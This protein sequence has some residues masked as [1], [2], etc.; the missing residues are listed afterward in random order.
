MSAFLRLC[1]NYTIITDTSF[2][3]Q[4]PEHNGYPLP[5]A[6]TGNSF[7]YVN[8]SGISLCSLDL[9]NTKNALFSSM[10]VLFAPHRLEIH[11]YNCFTL[12]KLEE[13]L[14]NRQHYYQPLLHT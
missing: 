2:Q 9:S 8:I 10:Y 5:S 12:Y 4:S 14:R 11:S 13:I 6:V 3:Y 7:V 1:L